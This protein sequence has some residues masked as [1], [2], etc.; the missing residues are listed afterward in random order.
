M[1][2]AKNAFAQFFEKIQNVFK[3]P[4]PQTAQPVAF[5]EAGLNMKS[6]IGKL[7]RYEIRIRKAVNT[8]MQ[9]DARSV[10]KGSGLEFDDVR[11][12]QYGDD[13]RTVNWNV[14]AKG[15]GVY[16]N[17]YKEEKEQNIFIILDV[18]ESQQ[19]GHK[20]KQKLDTGKELAGV[21]TLSAIREASSVGILAF[22]DQKEA[23]VRPDKGSKQASQIIKVLYRL[24]PDSKKTDLTKAIQQAMRLIKRKSVIIL[25]SDFID[26]NYETALKGMSQKHDLI[27]LHLSD[28][29]EQRFPALGIVPILDKETG[30]KT[31]VNT[32]S[33]AFRKKFM[34]QFAQKQEE[35]EKI[36]HQ[37][38]AD[39]VG[40]EAGED[41]VPKLVKLFKVRKTKRK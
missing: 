39:Y 18:S 19:V 33:D 38:Q 21:L 14:S 26:Q 10:F 7:R 35:L 13:V 28:Q 5:G 4:T 37:Y 40:I 20:G 16:V 24:V 41:F 31:W 23:Y 3:Q 30:K 34:N 2:D 22:S 8:S 36:C 17:T 9:G 32:N 11:Q 12:Y 15:H 27:C 29:R 25:I 1:A 6:I